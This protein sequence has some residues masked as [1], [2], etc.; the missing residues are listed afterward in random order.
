MRVDIYVDVVHQNELKK[1]RGIAIAVL[2][3]VNASGVHTRKIIK[4]VADDTK[5]ALTLIV[6]TSALKELVKPCTVVL[7]TD[8]RYIC[9]AVALNY[10]EKWR[11][12]DWKKSNSKPIA[13]QQLWKKLYISKQ[14]H[15]IKTMEYV[16]RDEFVEIG[17][18][19]IHDF[20][21][22]EV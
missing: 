17:Q 10:L 8:N 22:D 13:N 7:H 3:V 16:Q 9:S 1:G 4:E 14:M 11:R 12:N 15:E 18:M 20:L 5:N 19:N 6:I 2:E 21:K